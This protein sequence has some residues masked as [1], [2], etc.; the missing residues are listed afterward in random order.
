MNINR[1]S[2]LKGAALGSLAGVG[3]SAS[4]FSLANSLFSTSGAGRRPDLV[5]V[6]DAA[7]ESLF[8]QG[9]QAATRGRTLNVQR[10]D[11]SLGFIQALNQS[12]RSGQP[13]RLIGLVDDASAALIIE[14]ARSAGASLQWLGQHA[15]HPRQS[16]H[17]LLSA[18]AAH[19]C[20]AQLGQQLNACGN[21]FTLQEHR[22]QAST[23]ALEL[24]AR[25]RSDTGASQWAVT[26][27]FALAAL[28][29]PHTATA[30]L[31]AASAPLR[32]HFVS[33]S[34]ET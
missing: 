28:G 23:P 34:I 15:A 27:G 8:V 33:F 12:L 19:G 6:S 13:L 2:V 3:L 9:A 21:G 24:A 10:T 26:L 7:S 31:I 14:T 1:R 4:G 32:G 25:H 18:Q 17:R 29:T 20:S 16:R 5:L 11:L 30:P 22:M